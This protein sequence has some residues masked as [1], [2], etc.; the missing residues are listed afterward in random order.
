MKQKTKTRHK[1]GG[2]EQKYLFNDILAQSPIENIL[3][4]LCN[5]KKAGDGYLAT[6]PCHDDKKQSLSISEGN[7]GRVLL[8]CHANCE[9]KDIL[10]E[11]ELEMKNLFP[12]SEMVSNKNRQTI[13]ETYDYKNLA[14]KLDYQICRMQPKKDFRMR[15]PDGRGGW[16]WDGKG[17]TPYPYRLPEITAALKNGQTVF[18]VEGEKDVNNLF[19]IGL[20]ATCNHGGAGKWREGHALYFPTGSN[21]VVI[22][23]NDD[24]GKQ[25]GIIVAKLL[26][27]RGCKVKVIELPGIPP[28]GDISDWL[29]T[30]HVNG[31][32]D[33]LLKIVE[34]APEWI[35]PGT[36]EN[37]SGYNPRKRVGTLEE[38]FTDTEIDYPEEAPSDKSKTKRQWTN[39]TDLGNAEMLVRWHGQNL[40]FVPAWGKWL[41]WDG[42]RWAADQ[43]GQIRR[44]ARDTVRRMYKEASKIDDED[45]RKKLIRHALSSESVTR[46]KAMIE[47]AGYLEEIPVTPEQL[48]SDPWLL[49][50]LNGTLDLRTGRLRQPS[51]GDLITKLVPINYDPEA[52]APRWEA[53]LDQIFGGS[54]QLIQYAKKGAGYNLTGS[55]EEHCLF[56]CHGTGRNGKST[57]LQT[58]ANVLGQD[59]SQ[60]APMSTFMVKHNET[61]PNDI[62]RLRGSRFVV[63]A[64][65]EE[66]ARLAESLIKQL[67]GG[68]RITARFLHQEFFEFTPQF[69]IWMMTNHKPT[70]RGTDIA[71]WERIKL[72]P[73]EVTIPSDQR[74]PK[75]MEKLAAEAEG[76]LTWMAQGCLLWQQE[77]LKP[78]DEVKNATNDYRA[79][80]DT[81]GDF[82]SS[83]CESSTGGPTPLKWIYSRY[84][85]WAQESGERPLTRKAFTQRLRERGISI[86]TGHGN[87]AYVD[88][89]TLIPQYGRESLG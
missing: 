15:R 23:D 69:K 84:T 39:A 27:A 43:T 19:S 80:M 82:L 57:M 66:N 79:Q 64:E 17:I 11:L 53:F 74:D 35:D 29:A 56:V 33:E 47:A 38:A 58:L 46:Q 24:P 45:L 22:T 63:A 44:L 14:G 85:T 1:P 77:G 32:K 51:R 81:V 76:I 36:E 86:R 54:K 37:S 41:T 75:L 28:K 9:T 70:I 89:L 42:K 2:G 73:F 18:V 50:C 52:K 40:R 62:A 31:A 30:R 21:I 12:P 49:N 61:I 25:H 20:V 88:N 6:C 67:T 83:E 16:I 87:L 60:S 8:H 3:S 71:I 4:R 7:D 59:Y 5:V 34:A 68:D 26:V 13:K 78:P 55:T 65:S 72:I 10:S 48:D